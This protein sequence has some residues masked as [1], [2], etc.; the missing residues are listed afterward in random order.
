VVERR[1]TVRL[2][3][4]GRVAAKPYIDLRGKVSTGPEQGLLSI[5]FHPRFK[6]NGLV[7]AAYTDPQG[8]LRVVRLKGNARGA[9]MPTGSALT[10]IEI[11]HPTWTNH[12]GG[13]LA[14]GKDGL[15]YIST[16]DGGG[17][18]DPRNNAQNRARLLGKVL[19]IDLDN[20]CCGR[21]YLIPGTNPY[22]RVRGFAPEIL[23]YGLR[24]PWRFSID[25]RTG[26]LWV[27]DVGQSLREEVNLLGTGERGRNL[28]WDC[29]EGTVD[30]SARHGGR[31]CAGRSFKA[32]LTSY[33]THAG[34]RCAVIGGY[35]YRGRAYASFLDGL[36]VYA[37]HCSGELLGTAHLGGTRQATA[38]VGRLAGA[39][40][41]AFGE[42]DVGEL[43]AV[44]LAGV[45]Y[46]VT[47]AR[48]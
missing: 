25:R 9:T 16:G 42:N 24:N 48:R 20:A 10:M 26:N 35:V 41:T 13:Q 15:L 14:F 11:P 34:G 22:A 36:Y 39:R 38:V 30:V 23:H 21:R 40:L 46:R 7:F 19:R 31:Y 29:R 33:T 28:G 6:S 5:A 47:A 44:S 32:P 45:L 37:D 2:V 12:N 3:S 18:G 17:G 4:R 8:D 1:G 27:A 43:Y